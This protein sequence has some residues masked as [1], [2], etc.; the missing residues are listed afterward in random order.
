MPTPISALGITRSLFHLASLVWGE[1]QVVLL[2]HSTKVSV[3]QS[4]V[5]KQLRLTGARPAQKD[6]FV[7]QSSSWL[8]LSP[9]PVSQH[10][11]SPPRLQTLQVQPVSHKRLAHEKTEQRSRKADV[12]AVLC[13][14][15]VAKFVSFLSRRQVRRVGW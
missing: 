9:I 14:E 7:Q 11:I 1:S 12:T 3:F 6:F 15:H 5:G 10:L 4:S 2:F 13:F 8:V